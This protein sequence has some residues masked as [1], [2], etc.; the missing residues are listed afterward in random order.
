[1]SGGEPISFHVTTHPAADFTVSIYRIGHYGGLGAR[2]VTQSPVCHGTPQPAPI[3]DAATGLTTCDWSVSWRLDVPTEWVSGLYTAV[4]TTVETGWR[5]E[6]PFVVRDDSRRDTMCVVLP[7]TTYQAYNHFPDD[8]VTG[9]DLYGGVDPA[10]GLVDLELRATHMSFDRPYATA[11]LRYKMDFDAD[12]IGFLERS[13]YDV[14]Y[15][16][17]IDLHAGRVDPANYRAMI[18]TG[19]DEYWSGRMR[20]AVDG[21]VVDGTHLAFMAANNAYWN[22]R[23]T[24]SA[25]GRPDRVMVCYKDFDDPD[26][27]AYGATNLWRN[28]QPG[29]PGR[30]EQS[31][32]GTQYRYM[33]DGTPPL[34]VAASD[35]WMWAGT[36]VADGDEIADIVAGEA[37]DLHPEF[38]A[39]AGVTQTL[40]SRS[41]YL[42]LNSDATAVQTTS[43]YETTA[44]TIVFCAG[45]YN[46]ARGL[47]RQR[48]RDGRIQRATHNL[49]A[50]FG[51]ARSAEPAPVAENP[52]VAENR[53]MGSE[54]WQLGPGNTRPGADLARVICGY[55]SATSVNSGDPLTFHVRATEDFTIAIY[56]IGYY[57]GIGSRHLT[58]SPLLPATRQSEP[59]T[60]PDT[61]MISCD[62]SVTWKLDVPP[63]WTS[64]L[65]VTVFTTVGGTRTYTPFVV[66]DDARR[67]QLCLV[68]P[69][70]TCQ[71]HNIWPA[72]GVRG[73]SLSHGYDGGKQVYASRA[74]KVSFDRPYT[75]TGLPA[76]LAFDM[77]VIRWAEREGYDLTY[78]TSVDLHDGRIDPSRHAGL[79]FAGREQYWS[80]P[81]RATAER[82]VAGGTSLVFLTAN[83]M[84]WHA[85]LEP[86]PDGRADRV[87]TCFKTDPDTE[88][89]DGPTTVKWRTRKPGPGQ[90]EQTLMGVQYRASVATPVPLVVRNADH[91]LWAGTELGDGDGVP[92]LVGGEADDLDPR[93]PVPPDARQTLLSASPYPLRDGSVQIQNTSVYEMANGAIVF[94]AGTRMW[95]A[96]L[97]AEGFVDARIQRATSNLLNRIGSR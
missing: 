77:H 7:F 86:A 63:D 19:H 2:L 14:T 49:L 26:P 54:L 3:I 5:S 16:T 38:P 51:A 89:G 87:V 17:S 90:A 81:M 74:H 73:T 66:R 40:L 61:R 25:D 84:Q 13:G 72:D 44:G 8:G 55:A 4:F 85:R 28:T 69:F 24:P 57:D 75:K 52:T 42:D 95:T 35:H 39:V 34:V 67:S 27:D 1:M 22:V 36:G 60:D 41:P 32:I 46:W 65:Y 50:R 33:V 29:M 56:R 78:A 68:L 20:D 11:D 76:Q 21:A 45:T 96:A 31:L 9:R 59:V 53:A 93:Y 97:D 18:F 62:W 64:G 71:A 92:G 30:P 58:T 48:H 12:V 79:V 82:A 37:D 91:W 83:S 6:A 88:A 80:A 23:L 47:N 43:V 15:A 10:T 70:A 94:A